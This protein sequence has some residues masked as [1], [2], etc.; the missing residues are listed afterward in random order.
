MKSHIDMH[1]P[2]LAQILG[3]HLVVLA[4]GAPLVWNGTQCSDYTWVVHSMD[5]IYLQ[6]LLVLLKSVKIRMQ[7][8]ISSHCFPS[9]LNPSHRHEHLHNGLVKCLRTFLQFMASQLLKIQTD[10]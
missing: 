2:G 9:T 6:L 10:L 3:R 5:L 4:G 7:N 8:L 1:P